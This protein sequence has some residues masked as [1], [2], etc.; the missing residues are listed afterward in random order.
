MRVLGYELRK[1]F[2]W[3]KLLI[4]MAI[5]LFIYQLLLVFYAEHFPNGSKVYEFNVT[6][7]MV[8]DYGQ[9]MDEAD[10]EH[11]RQ[12]YEDKMAVFADMIKEDE[13]FVEWGVTTFEEYVYHDSHLDAPSGLRNYASYDSDGRYKEVMGD[14]YAHRSIIERYETVE[15]TFWLGPQ[16]VKHQERL[17][18]ITDEKQYKSILPSQVFYYFTDT[19]KYAT[20]AI[21]LSIMVLVIPIYIGDRRKRL[22]E[23]Q[24]A[25]RLGRRLYWIK[26][27]AA[28][29]GT[30]GLTTIMMFLYTL[31]FTQHD[32]SMFFDSRINSALM[33]QVY[34]FNLTLGQYIIISYAATYLLAFTIC[35]LTAWLSR[36]TVLYPA[37][38]GMIVPVAYA[39]LTVGFYYLL[40]RMFTLY[41]AYWTQAVGYTAVVGLAVI[42]VIWRGRKEQRLDIHG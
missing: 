38:I 15:D 13:K 22:L 20:A 18:S 27:T 30:T 19:H 35:L 4:I 39:V 36:L 7:Q 28:F 33:Y 6:V 14:L 37:L 12:M 2:H 5:C 29:I 8:A 34:W 10:L 42:L 21:L 16:T 25:S 32:I 31:F 3:K 40:D 26:L 17:Q 24:Y 1:M 11:F 9:E 41:G 23:V